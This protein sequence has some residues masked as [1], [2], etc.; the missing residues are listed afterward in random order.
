[1]LYSRTASLRKSM[2]YMMGIPNK[3]ITGDLQ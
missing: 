3:K 2:E 1:L